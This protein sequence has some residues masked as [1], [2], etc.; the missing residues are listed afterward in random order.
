VI[1]ADTSAWVEFLRDTPHPANAGL[2]RLLEDEAELVVT[3]VVVMELLAGARSGRHLRDL[4][5]RLLSFP[6][7]PLEGLADYE[8]AAVIYRTCRA[9]GETIRGLADCLIAVPA[10]RAGARVLHNDS[11]FEA[12]ARH[13][14]L[15]LHFLSSG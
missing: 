13:T 2:A 12:I 4:R 8:E 1:L 15:E 9:A 5:S 6:I 7:L 3:E 14:A 11:D 10:I